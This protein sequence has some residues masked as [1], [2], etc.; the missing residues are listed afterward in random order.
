L[1]RERYRSALA[2]RSAAT[3]L[4]LVAAAAVALLAASSADAATTRHPILFVHGVEGTGAQF[5]SQKLRFTSNGYPA[6]WIDEVDYDST[7]GAA[8]RSAVNAQIDRRI[9]AL[10]QRT[11]S[12]KV[13]VVAH[14]LGTFVTHDYLT[15]PVQGAARRANLAHYINVDGQSANPGVRTLAVWA[16]IPL[17]GAA[18]LGPRH[19]DGAQNVTIPNQTHVQTCTSRE[20]FARYFEFL[21]GKSPAHDIVRRR[22]AIK[23]AGRALTF[24][25]NQGLAGATIQVWPLTADGHRATSAPVAS[26]AVTD[27]AEGGGAWGPVT[28]QA[29][30]RYEFTAVRLGVGTLHYYYEPFVRRDDTLRLLDSEALIAYTGLRPGSVSSAHIRYKELWGDRP[31]QTDD[32]RIDGTSVCT[33]T[34]CPT[35]KT[36]N[37]FFAFDRNHDGRTDL[38][39]PDPVLGNVPFVAGGDVF[40]PSSPTA[41]GTVRFQLRSRGAG[42]LRTVETPNWDAQ[43]DGA[44][45]QWNDFEPSEVEAA[46]TASARL[47]LA[48]SPRVAAIGCHRFAFRVTSRSRT[49]AGARITFGG[50]RVRSDSRGRATMRVCFHRAGRYRAR[51]TKSGYRSANTRVV[52]RR[53][54]RHPAFTG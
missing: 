52:V 17:S 53:R 33:A 13:D 22:G 19:M 23:V 29:G 4:A 50:G 31:G 16:G 27:G 36:V 30:K 43:T 18:S 25:Q 7:R 24:P 3:L 15:D 54:P 1:A 5:E 38:S 2:G 32:L 48:A 8:D 49:V 10:K 26:V 6:S 37:A 20:S 11:G 34:L 35:R 14:S 46:S 44:L 40:V 9:A 42:P 47:S 45:I 12:S 39:T 51:A 28:V 41:A 21:T